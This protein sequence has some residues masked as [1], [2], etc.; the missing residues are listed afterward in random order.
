MIKCQNFPNLCRCETDC[1][2]VSRPL[3]PNP[4]LD[5]KIV[6]SS[7]GPI[8]LEIYVKEYI[9]KGYLPLG[10]FVVFGNVFLQSVY[11]PN[12]AYKL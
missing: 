12:P 11:K 1:L 5:Y 10:G 6:A 4:A 8:N 2:A 7:E 3:G 9:D